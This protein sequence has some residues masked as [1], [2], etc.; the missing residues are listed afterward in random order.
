MK[1][2]L[3]FT[4]IVVPH[5]KNIV[6]KNQVREYKSIKCVQSQVYADN[7]KIKTFQTNITSTEINGC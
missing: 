2:G 5:I 6:Q 1:A 4:A 3:P 7:N